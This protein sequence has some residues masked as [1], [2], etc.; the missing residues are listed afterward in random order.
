MIVD[1]VRNDIGV[2]RRPAAFVAESLF[3]VERHPAV[4]QM[5][6]TVSGRTA[7]GL[8]DIFQALSRRL[9]HRRAQTGD[10]GHYAE[11]ETDPRR[12]YTGCM[13]T[14]RLEVAPSST[15]RSAPC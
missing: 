12:V 10:D 8:A 14:R 5:T 11:L 3:D 4:W 15:W 9:D 13:D 1:M 6:S 2:S 7:A